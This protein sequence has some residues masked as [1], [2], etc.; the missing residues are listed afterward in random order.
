[1]PGNEVYQGVEYDPRTAKAQAYHFDSNASKSTTTAWTTTN[2]G[3]GAIVSATKRIPANQVIVGFR[4]LRP[5]QLRG[6]TTL[7]P[8]LLLA[9]QL[10]DYLEAEI[11]TAQRAARWLAFVTSQDPEATMR[12]F[13]GLATV[14]ATDSS[15]S[16]YYTMEM[17]NAIIDFLRSGEQVT[18]ANHNRPGDSFEPF[19]KFILRAFAACVGVPYPMVSG[20]Y[21]DAKY[22]S[23][24]VERND[25]LKSVAI[26]RGRLIRQLCEP[27]KREFMF[28]AVATGKLELP[29]YMT[30][31]EHYNRAVW[32]E[33]GMEQLDPLREGRAESDAVK[34]KLRSPHEVLQARGRDPEQVLDEWAEWRQMLEDRNLDMS[35]DQ[36]AL[37]TNPAAVSDQKQNDDGRANILPIRR[38]EK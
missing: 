25:M 23:A 22:T 33:P 38:Q 14:S 15:E 30:S 11:A 6:V 10:R 18:I 12:S 37:K 21:G 5:T 29:G 19:V 4:S 26:R 35:D 3:S 16:D 17:G 32:M 20:D 8:V 27:V 34:D 13:G 7:A 24:R 1:L 28:W 2:I 31:P 9:H 36:A